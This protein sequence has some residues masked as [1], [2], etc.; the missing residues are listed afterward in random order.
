M[1]H[2][3]VGATLIPEYDQWRRRALEAVRSFEQKGLGPEVVAHTVLEII[4]HNTSRLRHLI[5]RQ[6]H[7]IARLRRFL[8]AALYEQG[9]RRNF[10]LDA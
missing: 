4:S 6:A 10:S 8:P 7:S 2:R 9:V 1:N 3:Q 5:G